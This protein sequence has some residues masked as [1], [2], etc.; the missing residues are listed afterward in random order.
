MRYIQHDSFSYIHLIRFA[1]E[2]FTTPYSYPFTVTRNKIK[3]F[4]NKPGKAL[5]L[6]FFVK[7]AHPNDAFDARRRI[8]TEIIFFKCVLFL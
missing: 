8:L 2:S 7:A 6:P 1:T 4:L 5:F 3:S